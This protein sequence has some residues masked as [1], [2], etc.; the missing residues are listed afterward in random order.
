MKTIT[1]RA[2]T[3]QP[4]IFQ[5]RETLRAQNAQKGLLHQS[6]VHPRVNPALPASL[7]LQAAA[8]A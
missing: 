1:N 3:V 4:G 6:Q 2:I 5:R 8:G 7:P